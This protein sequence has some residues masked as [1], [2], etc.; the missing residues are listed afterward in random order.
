V[1]IDPAIGEDTNSIPQQDPPPTN[2]G[3][4][5]F[6]PGGTTIVS[7]DEDVPSANLKQ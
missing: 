6:D 1:T 2:H 5:K 3:P 4:E 7:D